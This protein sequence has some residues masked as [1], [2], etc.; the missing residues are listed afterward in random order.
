MKMKKTLF[1]LVMFM[2]AVCLNAADYYMFKHLEVKDGLS[3]NLITDIYKDSRGYM[4]FGTASGLNKYDGNKIT[5]Y[6]SLDENGPFVSNYIKDIQEDRNGHLWIGTNSGD[7]TVYNPHTDEFIRDIRSVMWEMGINGTPNKTFID[8]N[9]NMWFYVYGKG[10]YFFVPETN[11]LF[12]LL[13]D[14][15]LPEGEVKAMSECSEGIVII[16]NT[17]KVICVDRSNNK[18]KWEL[19]PLLP[20][21]KYA[22]F[23]VYVDNDDDIWIYSIS[24][25]W[26]YNVLGKKWRTDI[27]K[28]ALGTSTDMVQCVCQSSNGLVWIGRDQNGIC[29]LDKQTKEYQILTHVEGDERS[30]QQNAIVSLYEDVNGIMWAGTYKKGVS[31]YNES[32]FKF[33]VSHVGDVNSVVEDVDGYLWIGTND[34][35]LVRWHKTKGIDKRYR[36]NTPNSISADVIVAM[37]KARDGKLWIGTFRGGVNC[38]DK[39]KFT[40][41]RH[42]PGNP[43]SLVNDNIWSLDEDKEG[44]IWIGTLGGGVQCLNPKTGKF[45]TYNMTNGLISDYI[46]SVQVS[47]DNQLLVATSYGMSIIDLESRQIANFHGPKSGNLEFSEQNLNQIYQDSRGLLWIATRS[48]VNIYDLRTDK[49]VVLTEE[50][51]LSSQVITGITEDDNKNI[52]LATAKGLTNVIPSVDAK[53]SDYSFRFYTYSDLD[54][55]QNC[56]FNMRSLSKLSNGELVVGGMYGVNYFHPDNIK[57]NKILPKVIFTGLSLFNEEVKVGKEYDNKV[58]LETNLNAQREIELKYKQNVFSIDFASDNFVLPEKMKYAYKLDG[59]STDWLTTNVGKVTYTN[60][61]PGTYTLKVKAINSDGYSGDEEAELKIVIKPPFW[62]T[63]WAYI[64]YVLL[65]LG[66]VFVARYFMLRGER[67]KFKMQQ[68][69]QE[70]D[71][72]KEINDMKLHFFTNV[73]HELRTPLTLILSPMELLM[74]ERQD[75]EALMNKLGMMHRNATRLLNLVNQLLDFRRGDEKGHNLE[76]SEGDIV[77]YTS[78]ICNSFSGMTE[79]K[80][81]HLTF[82]SSVPDLIMSFDGDKYNK[83]VMN[84]LS[85]AFKFTPENGRVDVSMNVL[86][87]GDGQKTLELKVADTGVGIKDE[88][89]KR[90]FERF[91][92][93]E[94]KNV[95]VTGSGV[96]L[97]LVSEFVRLHGGTVDVMDNVPCGSVFI[98]QMPIRNEKQNHINEA[99]AEV[100]NEDFV[101]VKKTQENQTVENKDEASIVAPELIKNEEPQTIMEP[102]FKTYSTTIKGKYEDTS[103]PLIVIVD[104]NEDFLSFMVDSFSKNYRIRTAV[105]GRE[106]WEMIPELMPDLIISDVMMPEMDGNQLC[107]LVKS[108]KRTA[109]IPLIL[110]TSCQSK[111]Y[112]LEGL[113]VGADDYITKP[114]S[115]DILSL[116]IKKLMDLHASAPQRSLIDPS[117][118]E[119]VIT[120]LDE[121]LIDNAVKYVEDNISRSDLSVEELSQSLGMSRVHLYKKLVAITGKT[122]IEFIRVI[123]LKRAAQLLRESQQ[124]VSEVAYQVGFNNPKYFS[125]YFKDE[126]G[127]LPS[128]YQNMESV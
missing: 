90:I 91:Y 38:Y 70:A 95:D 48:G 81:V 18:I 79:K 10:V 124:N 71:K 6:Q 125:K 49:L 43:N 40:H 66:L 9:K 127:V 23:N 113:T 39:G 103:L 7:Y 22:D 85:N 108:D 4:W 42:I 64:I 99:P 120:S 114:F 82:F 69:Q 118:S 15:G 97:S 80:H 101:I 54:G 20:Q 104:D 12:P 88:D 119:I 14:T 106:A 109:G 28:I 112:K 84:L 102:E 105:N 34:E 17:G 61:S 52:W 26:I 29:I 2:F 41:Y 50:D 46:A 19:D 78:N 83:I 65:F 13:H 3:N 57:Y 96:G 53:S 36:S 27:A 128:A 45:D 5:V 87:E 51:G 77:S 92:Q 62:L 121:K 116:R 63:T 37:K 58:I 56:E 31:Y 111:E 110:L 100:V 98:V 126:F 55:L 32:T 89:K 60:L 86:D 122:P 94:T 25:V 123:R 35:G 21:G 67:N 30:L 107:K 8:K 72:N 93:V 33:G 16:F 76:M 1:F 24:G 74:K 115:I 68:M 11:L 117:P 75:D 44:N 47:K 73:S 59:F